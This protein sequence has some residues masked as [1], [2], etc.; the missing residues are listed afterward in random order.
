[1]L[2]CIKLGKIT[3]YFDIFTLSDVVNI[4]FFTNFATKEKKD[5]IL[6]KAFK[7]H[8]KNSRKTKI[9]S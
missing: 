6:F 1:M 3:T 7:I 5:H 4:Q 9:C 2:K 8:H